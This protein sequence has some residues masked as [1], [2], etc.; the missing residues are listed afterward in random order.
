MTLWDM[1]T[2]QTGRIV[3]L[4]QELGTHISRRLR[5]MGFEEGQLIT[6][7]RRSPLQG[8]LVVQ[9]RDS[10]YSLEQSVARNIK[11]QII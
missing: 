6:C 10:V 1:A 7:I 8:P 11:L 4:S 5:E 2:K 9:I 3:D